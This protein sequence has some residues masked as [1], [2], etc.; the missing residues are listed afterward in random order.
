MKYSGKSKRLQNQ[1][2][3][4]SDY[5]DGLLAEIDEAPERE[6]DAASELGPPG[7][8]SNPPEPRL[9]LETASPDPVALAP[10]PPAPALP[11]IET[12]PAPEPEL[13][14]E[15]EPEP[16][17]VTQVPAPEVSESVPPWAAEPF[18]CLLFEV[19]GLK[20][21]VPLIF[22]NGVLPWP[23]NITPMPNHEFWFLGLHRHLETS[24]KVV[25]TA[26]VVVPEERRKPVTGAPLSAYGNIILIDDA[27]WGLACTRVA[28]MVNLDPARVRW[29]SAGG[30]RAWLA[31]TVVEHMCALLD[32]QALARVLAEG[33]K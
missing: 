5:L 13:I 25:D 33:Q 4:L 28:E 6:A 7:G 27:R 26:S 31:G 10:S 1:D 17:I 20:L 22:L 12:P 18:P 16:V 23:E 19:E 8:P 15:P 11:M 21:A 3:A 14:V 29:R 24:V 9:S 32:V 30:Q 2:Q